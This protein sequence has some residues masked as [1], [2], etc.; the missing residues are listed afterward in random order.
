MAREIGV[1]QLDLWPMLASCLGGGKRDRSI[2]PYHENPEAWAKMKD[3]LDEHSVRC[4]A[5]GVQ[6]FDSDLGKSRKVF[7]WAKR[8]GIQS[9]GAVP[10]SDAFDGLET[11]VEEYEINVAIHNHGPNDQHFGKISQVAEAVKGRHP[12]IGACTDLGHFWRAG[13]DPVKA[14]EILGDR[15]LAV[16]LK[17]QVSE[18]EQAV[19]G[20]G[21]MDILAI[22]KT[23]KKINYKGP[24][25]LEYEA[26]PENP[27]P[28]MAASLENIRK[29][30][31]KMR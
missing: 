26:N 27:L 10:S 30:Y 16:H 1:A 3:A 18:T 29:L 13:E 17:D 22:L 28:G 14:L 5:Y 15:V 21:K 19:V 12:R 20:E 7:E 2:K 4:V 31:A 8:V 6:R 23:L 9:F 11:L 25:T 24:L